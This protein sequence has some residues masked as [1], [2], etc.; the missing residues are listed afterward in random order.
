MLRELDGDRV[1]GVVGL[2]DN[3]VVDINIG[4]FKGGVRAGNQRTGRRKHRARE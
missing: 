2:A 3:G 4:I 1:D